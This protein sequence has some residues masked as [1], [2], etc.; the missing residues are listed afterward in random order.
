VTQEVGKL[1]G[2][3]AVDVG[4][5]AGGTSIVTVTSDEPINQAALATAVEEAGYTVV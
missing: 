2:V 4:L 5:V 1:S 3:Q